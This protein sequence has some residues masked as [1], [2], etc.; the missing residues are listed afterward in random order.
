MVLDQHLL[1][2]FAIGAR[3]ILQTGDRVDCNA[4]GA[5]VLPCA[6]FEAVGDTDGLS[7]E[8]VREPIPSIGDT[9]IG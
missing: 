2:R 5:R 3:Q 8:G 7:S 9:I 4:F 6:T 1:H